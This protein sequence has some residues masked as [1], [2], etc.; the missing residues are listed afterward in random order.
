MKRI[1]ENKGQERRKRQKIEKKTW[2][3]KKISTKVNF[4]IGKRVFAV[5]KSD[6]RTDWPSH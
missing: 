3:E 2:K 5:R 1:K 4:R 6:L